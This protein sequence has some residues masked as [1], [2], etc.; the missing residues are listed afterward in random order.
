[1]TRVIRPET[2][3]SAPRRLVVHDGEPH[4]LHES[5]PAA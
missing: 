2:I 1:L 4:E 3:A 5:L